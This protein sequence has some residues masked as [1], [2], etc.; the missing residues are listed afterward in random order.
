MT[1]SLQTS[2]RSAVI[3]AA[4][5]AALP[6]HASV[7]FERSVR[8]YQATG[9]VSLQAG[10]SASVCATNKDPNPISILVVLITADNG[11][12]LASQEATLQPSTGVCL[13]YTRAVPPANQQ[14][15]PQVVAFVIP[16]GRFI[17]NNVVVQDAPG[18]GGCFVASVEIAASTPNNTVAQLVLHVELQRRIDN[19]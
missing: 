5:S 7:L 19:D 10:Q 2:I 13:D 11:S 4:F 9:P 8:D 17:Q 3:L 15:S 14:I 18:G 16:S 6:T 1:R 12:V